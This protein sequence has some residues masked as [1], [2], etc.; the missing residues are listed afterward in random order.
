MTASHNEELTA[1]RENYEKQLR[2]VSE[3]NKLL[4][5]RLNRELPDL[6]TRHAK[7]LSVFQSQLTNYKNTV[8]ALK[9]ELVNYC[10]AQHTAQAE[11][12]LRKSQLEDLTVQMEANRRQQALKHKTE[13]EMLQEQINLHK[14]QLDEITSKYVASSSVLESK[15]SI[16]RSLEQALTNVTVLRQDNESL[17]MKFDEVSAKY[18][19]AQSL[20]ENSQLHER[21]MSSRIFDLEKSLSRLSG[22]SINTGS[23]FN[24]TT[25]QTFDEVALQFQL[26]KQRLEEKAVMEKKLV[27]RINGL[28]QEVTEARNELEKANLMN[29]AYEK[30]LKDAKNS[31]DKFKGDIDSAKELSAPTELFQGSFYFGGDEEERKDSVDS[32]RKAEPE[33]IKLLRDEVESLKQQNAVLEEQI[34]KLNDEKSASSKKTKSLT[35]RL[36]RAEEESDQLKKGLAAAWQQCAE[37]EERLNQTLAASM[38][39]GNESA[40]VQDSKLTDQSDLNATIPESEASFRME[41]DE[42]GGLRQRLVELTTEKEKLI[43]KQKNYEDINEKLEELQTKFDE[44]IREQQ[45]LEE[46]NQNLINKQSKEDI[47]ALQTQ[48]QQLMNEKKELLDEKAELIKRNEELIDKHAKEIR[49]IKK[50][51]ENDAQKL[52]TLSLGLVENAPSLTE[53]KAEL[54]SRHSREMEELRTYFEQKCLQME[55]QY[56]EEVFSQQSKKMSDNDSEIEELTDDL[57]FGGGG[58]CLNVS[59]QNNQK[60]DSELRNKIELNEGENIIK[61]RL[62]STEK[63]VSI[64]QELYSKVQELE[65]LKNEY[66]RKLLEQQNTHRKE[67]KEFEERAEKRG[68]VKA[69]NQVRLIIDAPFLS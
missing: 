44:L 34:A 2:L 9:L 45:K 22:I 63:L 11:A 24:E 21:S 39:L 14:I 58:D 38:S 42:I 4:S 40:S 19:A 62:E 59:G 28:E 27:E 56:S 6:E 48:I 69:V 55:K 65:T 37:A 10:E 35:E 8:E 52:K 43:A 13:K 49:E 12:S 41:E 66:E 29:K 5:D 33:G 1:I 64:Q 15:E 47:N 32:P 67:L 7:E 16:E 26:T 51:T 20:I 53:M 30:Q 54:E 36:K 3:E 17:K 25:Y 18:S 31:H 68:V 57:Y 46:E 50:E 23:E 60:T 61:S